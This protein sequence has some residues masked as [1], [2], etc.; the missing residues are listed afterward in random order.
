VKGQSSS[1]RDDFYSEEGFELAR[2]YYERLIVQ[3][4]NRKHVPRAIDDLTFYPAMFSLWIYEVCEKRKRRQKQF[5]EQSRLNDDTMDSEDAEIDMASVIAEELAQ[6]REIANRM[7]QLII[8]PPFDKHAELLQ[9]RGM[10]G[11]WLGDLILQSGASHRSDDWE[12]DSIIGSDGD[13]ADE[14]TPE[15]LQR[16]SQSQREFKRAQESLDRAQTNGRPL[17]SVMHDVD[18]KIN[19]LSKKIAGLGAG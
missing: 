10:V 19:Q 5:E 9:L 6:A 16:L 1:S 14:S 17:T 11:L 12:K 13:E 4:P 18:T 3:H 2:E 15:K 8:S 7:D